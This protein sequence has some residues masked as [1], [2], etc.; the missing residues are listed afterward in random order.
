MEESQIYIIKISKVQDSGYILLLFGSKR[1]E[2]KEQRHIYFL[3]TLRKI[4]A[5]R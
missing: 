2:N 4:L 3:L 1:K 5:E